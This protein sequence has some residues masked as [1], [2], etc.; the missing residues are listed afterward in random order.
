[1]SAVRSLLGKLSENYNYY[2]KYGAYYVSLWSKFV[3]YPKTPWWNRIDD[4]I[5]LGAIPLKNYDHDEMLV[6]DE[7]IGYV[8]S[9][10]EMFEIEARSPITKPVQPADWAERKVQQRILETP[11]YGGVALEVIDRG[12]DTLLEWT[13]EID[14]ATGAHSGAGPSPSP[15][16]YVHCK[17]GR[18][19]SATIVGAYLMKKFGKT[20]DQALR[21]LQ[22]ERSVV[23]LNGEQF[24]G[25]ETY[26]ETR[27]RKKPF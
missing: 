18:G 6:R 27:C 22:N 10:V 16:I 20:P 5:V 4:R 23:H 19:R 24:R 14:K 15:S 21:I 9:M 1:M 17:A 7:R 2:Y 25:L 8:L 26:Y 13:A 3:L 12:V 11:D